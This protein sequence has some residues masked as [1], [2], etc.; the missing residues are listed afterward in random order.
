ME[1]EMAL[2]R[3]SSTSPLRTTAGTSD[4]SS[5]TVVATQEIFRKAVNRARTTRLLPKGLEEK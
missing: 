3:R 5:Q 4:G 2:E 1:A